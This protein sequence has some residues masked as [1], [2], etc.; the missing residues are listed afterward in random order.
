MLLVAAEAITYTVPLALWD[1]VPV[2]LA[3]LAWFVV[4]QTVAGSGTHLR[5]LATTG[6]VLITTGGLCK[7]LWKL[8]IAATDTDVV[9]L[10]DL[11][12]PLLSLGFTAVAA[13]LIA[14]RIWDENWRDDEHA[15]R[16]AMPAFEVVLL[17]VVGGLGWLVI[18][19]D[20]PFAEAVSPLLGIVVIASTTALVTLIR[21]SRTADDGRAT[22]ALVASLLITFGL[23]GLGAVEQTTLLQW[24]EETSNVI[25]Q[26]LLLLA[27][28]R[29]RDA[30]TVSIDALA[31][32][33]AVV[34][35][36]VPQN[37]SAERVAR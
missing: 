14:R 29:F 33:E 24:I 37:P 7:A 22:A 17:L 6:A 1:I 36:E 2:V 31:A 25:A 11:L 10:D 18:G 34:D 23:G 20:Q 19:G 3:G 27:A 32:L 21:W 35:V 26:G 12:F 30:Q 13:T 8:V 28:L 4:A 15:F 9:G 16:R 5:A